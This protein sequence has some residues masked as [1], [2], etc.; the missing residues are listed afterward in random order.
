MPYFPRPPREEPRDGPKGSRPLPT[1]TWVHALSAS[2]PPFSLSSLPSPYIFSLS[3]SEGFLGRLT[4][5]LF[6]HLLFFFYFSLYFNFPFPF[7]FPPPPRSHLVSP[8]VW[9]RGNPERGGGGAS[10]AITLP[11]TM[12]Y[13]PIVNDHFSQ[14]A[15]ARTPTQQDLTAFGWTWVIAQR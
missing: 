6:S 10:T 12:R 7:S 13:E 15:R 4:V 11:D 3:C 1:I 9:P 14:A 2:F 8:V 5:Y